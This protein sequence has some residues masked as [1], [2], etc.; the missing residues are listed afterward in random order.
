MIYEQTSTICKAA[1]HSGHIDSEGGPFK[2]KIANGEP[3]YD[4]SE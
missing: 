1:I 2:I 4:S 3:I